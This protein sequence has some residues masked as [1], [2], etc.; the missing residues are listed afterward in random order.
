MQAA[1]VPF[2]IAAAIAWTMR[3]PHVSKKNVRT[4][5]YIEIVKKGLKLLS[6]HRTLRLLSIDSILVASAAYF[7]FWLYQPLLLQF[8][9]PLI[10]FGFFN[11][12]LM[13]AQMI[14]STNFPF[15][16]KIAGSS[17]R[18]IQFGAIASAASF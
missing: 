12:F 15:L 10:Y 5:T 16:E 13:I 7:V 9:T 11:A 2:F 6:T 14:V 3:E 4:L 1:A 18:L 8:G 17:K